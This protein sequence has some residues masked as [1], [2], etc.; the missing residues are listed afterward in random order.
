MK[1]T[2]ISLITTALLIC[3]TAVCFADGSTTLTIEVPAPTYTLSIPASQIIPFGQVDTTLGVMKI[4]E[5]AGFTG[6]QK[7]KVNIEFDGKFTSETTSSEINYF[8]R[9]KGKVLNGE[10]TMDTSVKGLEF[11][12][13]NKGDG[14]LEEFATIHDTDLEMDYLSERLSVWIN[15]ANWANIDAGTYTSKITFTSQIV[16]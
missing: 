4:T 7:V 9:T 16:K 12:F 10:G 1:K 11:Y 8:L 14:T 13:Y 3:I 5:S 6:T 2:L 15:E